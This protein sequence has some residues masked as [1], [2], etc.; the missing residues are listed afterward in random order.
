MFV[1]G[2][3]NVEA[4][5][6]RFV[7]EAIVGIIVVFE[8]ATRV[9]AVPF[10]VETKIVGD[11]IVVVDAVIP[12]E[13]RFDWEIVVPSDED[14]LVRTSDETV[15]CEIDVGLEVVENKVDVSIET[16]VLDEEADVIVEL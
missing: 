2:E 12:E 14:C 10:T 7:E 4:R 15:D 8:E 9:G 13:V 3:T 5:L 16:E 6:V 1:V 11:G